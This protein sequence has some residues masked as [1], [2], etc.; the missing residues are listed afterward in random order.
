MWLLLTS[1]SSSLPFS[2]SL[3]FCSQSLVKNALGSSFS[4]RKYLMPILLPMIIYSIFSYQ[5]QSKEL[6]LPMAGK[7]NINLP[8]LKTGIPCC[9]PS[10]NDSPTD[11]SFTRT[12]SKHPQTKADPCQHAWGQVP[13]QEVWLKCF[14]VLHANNSSNKVAFSWLNSEPPNSRSN[15]G[16]VGGNLPFLICK[17]CSCEFLK[18]K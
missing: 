3:V 18:K 10:L 7:G 9:S 2:C 14:S 11:F 13:S 8:C 17:E 1:P 15:L 5:N 12:I 16:A 4:Q 6:S